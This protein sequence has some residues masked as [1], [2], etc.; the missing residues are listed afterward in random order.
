MSNHFA[1][2]S[3][4][5][6][7]LPLALFATNANDADSLQDAIKDANDG[8]STTITF[9]DNITLNNSMANPYLS[10]TAIPNLLPLGMDGKFQAQM[11][12]SITI[13]GGGFILNGTSS[14]AT[15]GFFVRGGNVAI[16]NLGFNS[17]TA[18]G[19]NSGFGG[20]GAGLG[21]SLF[22][23]TGTSVT[24]TN[25]SFSNSSAKGGD[26]SL[27]PTSRGGGGFA[28]SS[29]SLGGGGLYGDSLAN[30]GGGAA[31]D[32][33]AMSSNG[34]DSFDGTGGGT[35]GNPGGPGGG[36]GFEGNGGI[37][38]GGGGSLLGTGGGG[39]E[40]G[41]GGSGATGGNGN[42][43]GGGG[44]LNGDGG[45]GA[46]GARGSGTSFGQ[47]GFGGG[48]G[49]IDGI[50]G[51]GAGFGGAIFVRQGGTV[52]FEGTL[53]FSGSSIQ[54][55]SG[56][57][58][59]LALGR[60]IFAMSQANLIFNLSQDFAMPSAIEGNQGKIDANT[61]DVDTSIGGLTK[62]G[63]NRL[64]LM[65]DNTYTGTTT[66]E[67]GE[68]RVNGSL[69]SD[70]VVNDGA[71]FSGNCEVKIDATGNNGGNFINK[72]RLE[73]GND[74]VGTITLEG[75][76]MQQGS[77][78]IFAVDITPSGQ[79][80]LIA[81]D[82]RDA[83]LA[84]KLEVF[85][86]T[87]NYIAGTT[88]TVITGNTNGST[89]NEIIKVGPDANVVDIG[90]SYSSVVIT[91]TNDRIFED[92][93]I[94]DSSAKA[95]ANCMR[96]T[97]ITP[98]SDFGLL[99]EYLGT[100]SD[101]DVN[102]ALREYSP[103]I[104]GA[105]DWVSLRNSRTI[106]D[107]L[108]DHM[109]ELCCSK[110]QDCCHPNEFW[111]AGFG[112]F[113]HNKRYDEI[114]R[115]HSD[116]AGLAIG[117]DRKFNCDAFF[118]IAGGYTTTDL[119]FKETD[120]KGSAKSVWGAVYGSKQGDT[121]SL[122]GSL[123]VGNQDQSL[124]RSFNFTNVPR[125]ARSHPK[126]QFVNIHIGIEGCMRACSFGASPYVSLDYHIFNRR[127]FNEMGAKSANLD[128]L[129]NAQ[130]FLRP[131]LGLLGSYECNFGRHCFSPYFGIGWLGEIPLHPSEQEATFEN[132]TC[133]ID[134]KSYCRNNHLFAP[135]IG[136]KWTTCAGFSFEAGYQGLFNR[137][138]TANQFD[139]RLEWAF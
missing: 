109:V 98:G 97:A 119:D 61:P 133:L 5:F 82:T 104:F 91:I 68:L 137:K 11:G 17:C 9:T 53:S 6:F 1:L 108:S 58:S 73:P 114:E 81:M 24:L 96:L 52:R 139:G 84:G 3:L 123:I 46:G 20:G 65:G 94:I 70:V 128:V 130:S 66:V 43:A 57:N 113:F 77:N 2:K 19:G 49:I 89:F 93:D 127:S 16:N 118:G 64:S 125:K 31:F 67:E 116:A 47:G 136:F 103:A 26:S 32:S 13:Q 45:F 132:Q 72:G 22:V 30:G 120:S 79:A 102:Q 36:G 83:T 51:G 21:G 92:Q 75:I 33:P 4:L 59:G 54:G 27:P 56:G 41:G 23:D 105:F 76:Y 18:Q 90:V 74:G 95:V 12:S 80:D 131:E 10:M 62:K 115:F 88:Y 121:F 106:V 25:C 71:T 111:I 122:D 117:M 126:G 129:C 42:F 35:S 38:G 34:G 69:T 138:T 55:G 124:G 50:G 134:V 48:D 101:G 100:L 40:F 86:G 87:G 78:S 28:G 39:G 7:S 8:S 44:F 15:R 85:I 99:V 107:L 110:R 14:P 60:D 112:N 135:Q 37:G 63:A 29:L